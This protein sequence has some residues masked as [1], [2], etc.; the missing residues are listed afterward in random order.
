MLGV[1]AEQ[2][3]RGGAL[4]L[5][6]VSGCGMLAVGIVGNPWLGFVQDQAIEHR[7]V[8]ENLDEVLTEPKEYLG[9]IDYR[10]VDVEKLKTLEQTNAAQAAVV[11]N[12][13]DEAKKV[14]FR[15]AAIL[16]IVMFI[17]YVLLI[18]YFSTKGGYKPVELVPGEW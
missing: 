7:L 3:P 13:Q 15:K 8:Q 12:I 2:F 5:N 14:A 18:T 11:Q 17:V 10:S 9:L 6:L 16:P 1:V 4:T